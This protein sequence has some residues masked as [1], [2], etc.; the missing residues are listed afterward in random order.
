MNLNKYYELKENFF[1]SNSDKKKKEFGQFFTP[2]EIV[3]FM[4]KYFPDNINKL[5]ILDP[6]FGLGILSYY[7][8][9]TFENIEYIDAFELD[10]DLNEFNKVLHSDLNINIFYKDYISSNWEKK[11]DFIIA[12]PPY[13]KHHFIKEKNEFQ[14]I[15]KKMLK[16]NFDITTNIYC[17]FLLKSI[18]QL[19]D[20]GKLVYIVPSE[21]L[22]SNYGVKIKEFL[23]KNNIL[24]RIVKFDFNTDVF[25]DAI[26][27]SCILFI[28]KNKS[29]NQVHFSNIYKL[30]ELN[31]S[32]DEL[33][34]M[35]YN[36]IDLDSSKK[37]RIYF[38]TQEDLIE[39]NLLLVSNIGKVKRGIATGD[40]DYFI[41]NKS[42]AKKFNISSECLIPCICK[43]QY[44]QSIPILND[45]IVKKLENEDK[46]IFLFN[47]IFK[48]TIYDDSYIED[49]ERL[50]VNKK[51]LTSK[52]TPW[53]SSEKRESADLLISVF[54]RNK[55]KFILN[56]TKLLNLTCYHGLYLNE[57]IKKYKNLIFL[58]LNSET[59]YN[60]FLLEKREYGNGLSKFEPNDINKSHIINFNNIN[61]KDKIEL[62]L[63]SSEY[64]KTFS[65][66][67]LNRANE[68]FSSYIFK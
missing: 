46:E 47:G 64:L 61:R 15:F 37:W 58:Y 36:S 18:Y 7:L 34:T 32:F 23:L 8:T 29:S 10:D 12:N 59:A 63:L 16:T 5:K 14:S 66:E 25:E 2:L 55:L 54:N 38:E 67:L 50:G 44:L 53:Y 39:E 20:N 4:S 17:W 57:D 13:Y 3:K 48:K 35:T 40:N 19:S 43:T 24:E 65:D 42:K 62:E 52:R 1:N 21:F 33:K 30:E 31:K 26:T 28:N 11:Y 9:N 68:I 45:E 56:N 51:Y 22:N 6:S 60:L 41:F 49:G 27:T